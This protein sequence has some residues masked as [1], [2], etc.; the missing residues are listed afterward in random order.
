MKIDINC[1]APS[2]AELSKKRALYNICLSVAVAA[3]WFFGLQCYQSYSANALNDLTIAYFIAFNVCHC[4]GVYLGWRFHVGKLFA[5]ISRERCDNI[6][7]WKTKHPAI[8][9]YMEQV[10]AQKR[11]II[12]LEYEAFVSYVNKCAKSAKNHEIYQG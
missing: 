9:H 5:P 7:L 1:N 11:E 4:I 10:R 8:W 6:L 3:A 2:A 12:Y